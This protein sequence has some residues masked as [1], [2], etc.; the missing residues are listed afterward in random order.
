[1]F[2]IRV[3]VEL[4]LKLNISSKVASTIRLLKRSNNIYNHLTIQLFPIITRTI[5]YRSNFIR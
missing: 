2:I 5:N 3:I 4:I 1:M